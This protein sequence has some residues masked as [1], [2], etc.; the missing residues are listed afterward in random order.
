ML[1]GR[2][3]GAVVDQKGEWGVNEGGGES[4]MWR[5]SRSGMSLGS[6]DGSTGCSSEL[7]SPAS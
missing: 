7:V 6:S 2:R 5:D 3:G 1:E 4:V